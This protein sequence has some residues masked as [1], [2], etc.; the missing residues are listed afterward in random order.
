M[1]SSMIS[2]M[3]LRLQGAEEEQRVILEMNSADMENNLVN[4]GLLVF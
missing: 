1:I 2:F 4:S 3:I